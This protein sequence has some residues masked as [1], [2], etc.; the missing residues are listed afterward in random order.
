MFSQTDATWKFPLLKMF[1]EFPLLK[2]GSK[3]PIAQIVSKIP[4]AKNVTY[5][6][7]HLLTCDNYSNLT[8]TIIQVSSYSK[9][10]KNQYFPP[11]NTCRTPTFKKE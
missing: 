11:L 6:L 9:K 7:T 5:L 4:I 10:V 2:N 3:I 8:A 1:H